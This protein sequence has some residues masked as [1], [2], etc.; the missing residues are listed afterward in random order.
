MRMDNVES[1]NQSYDPFITGEQPSNFDKIGFYNLGYWKGVDNSVELA[2]INLI[3][4][5]VSFFSKRNG[6]VLDVACGR[7]ASSKFLTKYFEPTRIT[8]INISEKQLQVCKVLAPG[9]IFK[10]MNATKLDFSD[11]SFDNV[12]CIQSAFHFLTRL[13]FFEEAYRVLKPGGRLAVEDF[14]VHDYGFVA[15]AF[16]GSSKEFWPEE[17]YL[18]SVAA[19]REDLVKAGFRHVRV[20]DTT[21]FGVGAWLKFTIKQAERESDHK[22]LEELKMQDEMVNTQSPGSRG[23]SSCM[24]FAI[25]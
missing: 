2:Q 4:T 20:E 6:S 23:M 9:C 11:S 25:K 15:S 10:L 12:L 18:S 13:Q 7:G 16:P 8:G 21:Q 24:A 14:I 19:Y 3:E 22:T 17:N 5:L 1:I